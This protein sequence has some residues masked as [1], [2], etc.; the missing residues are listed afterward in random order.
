M[1]LDLEIKDG[2]DLSEDN[3]DIAQFLNDVHDDNEIDSENLNSNEAEK[4]SPETFLKSLITVRSFVQTNGASENIYRALAKLE[5]M[6]ITKK[7]S[8]SS[9]QTT[10]N[11]FF[12]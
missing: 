9:N 10:I 6:G 8:D 4:I 7:L 1:Q 3:D 2:Y 5:T 11:M 12:K